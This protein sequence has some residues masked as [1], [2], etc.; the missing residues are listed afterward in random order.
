MNN[1]TPGSFFLWLAAASF[2]PA[3]IVHFTVGRKGGHH[4]YDRDNLSG[5][6]IKKLPLDMM[7]KR[8][9]WQLK[10]SVAVIAGLSI[11]L[12]LYPLSCLIGLPI[13]MLGIPDEKLIIYATG[14]IVL[15]VTLVPALYRKWRDEYRQL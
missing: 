13:N 6:E 9:I 14:A 11:V 7:K 10:G 15:L 1:W 2:V 4:F 3:V 8:T 12:V 5:A